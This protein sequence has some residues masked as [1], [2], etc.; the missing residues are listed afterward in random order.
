[1]LD[2]LLRQTIPQEH[3]PEEAHLVWRD[4]FSVIKIDFRPIQYTKLINVRS[5]SFSLKLKR[6][7]SFF[8][9]YFLTHTESLY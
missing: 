3:C 1:M 6:S 8:I 7:S 4:L 5:S 9:F 2:I